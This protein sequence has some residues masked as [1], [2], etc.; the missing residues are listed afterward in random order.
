[1]VHKSCLNKKEAAPEIA[2]FTQHFLKMTKIMGKRW[3][4]GHTNRLKPNAGME[5]PGFGRADVSSLNRMMDRGVVEQY[6]DN[7][8]LRWWVNIRL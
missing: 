2:S 6:S 1:M 5:E 7:N 8:A 4:Q 3:T